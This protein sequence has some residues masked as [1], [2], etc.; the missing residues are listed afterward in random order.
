MWG[1]ST[2]DR[3]VAS[4]LYLARL[5]DIDLPKKPRLFSER[6]QALLPA[7]AA[8]VLGTPDGDVALGV[9]DLVVAAVIVAFALYGH[10]AVVALQ[11][12][13]VPPRSVARRR[14][15]RF[16]SGRLPRA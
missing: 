15:R 13:I 1:P 4:A 11:K 2:V 3:L 7:S 14:T 10:G 16:W 12:A 6:N 9:G 8:R 5:L